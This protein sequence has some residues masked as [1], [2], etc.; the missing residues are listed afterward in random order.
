MPELHGPEATKLDLLRRRNR[1]ILALSFLTSV[2]LAFLFHLTPEPDHIEMEHLFTLKAEWLYAENGIYES[3]SVIFLLG[4]VVVALAGLR[5]VRSSLSRVMLLWL[6]GLALVACGREL[7]MHVLVRPEYLGAMGMRFR[8]DWWIEDGPPNWLRLFWGAIFIAAALP[9]AYSAWHFRRELSRLL[10]NL[11]DPSLQMLA[12]MAIFWGIGFV[13]DDLLRRVDEIPMSIKQ[14]IEEFAESMGALC[15]L[16]AAIG[17]VT[18][19]MSG[20]Y[21]Q[22]TT[23]SGD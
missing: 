14:T 12:M 18:A 15:L 8:L 11:R 7:D 17:C 21:P 22:E 10:H 9:F 5:E 16:L 4:T 6:A 20:R 3:A 13:F 23:V 19:P 2:F 1:T